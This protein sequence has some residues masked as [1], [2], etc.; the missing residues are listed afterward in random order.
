VA[1]GCFYR[2]FLKKRVVE[3]GFFVVITW[4]FDGD[5]WFLNARVSAAENTPPF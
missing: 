4:F 5:L 1:D 3:D 2:V